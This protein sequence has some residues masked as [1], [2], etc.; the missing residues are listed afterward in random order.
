[1]VTDRAG[2][3]V[4]VENRRVTEMGTSVFS[5]KVRTTAHR[6]RCLFATESNLSAAKQYFSRAA[7]AQKK[8]RPRHNSGDEQISHCSS[9]ECG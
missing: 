7:C 3:S 8:A 9:T 2:Q 6:P 4:I 5:G 1:M